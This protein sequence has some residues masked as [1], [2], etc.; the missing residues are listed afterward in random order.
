M[1]DPPQSER[2][3]AKQYKDSSNLNARARLHA[4]FST[5]KYGWMRWVFDQLDLPERCRILELG[6]GPGWLWRQNL[7]GIPTGWDITLSDFSPG[8]LADAKDALADAGR[9]FMFEVIDAQ[10]IPFADESSDA[11]I[12]NHM[13]YHVPD[14][15]KALAEIRRVLKD[16]GRFYAT[17]NGVNHMKELADLVQPLAPELPFVQRANSKAFG[18]ENGRTKLE[19]C[20]GDVSQRRYEDSLKVPEAEPLAAW[21]LSVRGATDAFTDKNVAKLRHL[22]DKRIASTG[23]FHVTKSVGMFVA[24]RLAM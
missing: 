13:L 15:D 24:S 5:N 4:E 2:L 7:Q 17:T 6:C 14:L 9:A 20:F 12:A 21:V 8:I 3:L 18:L 19:R 22:I 16:G 11:L 10:T 23:S 1:S